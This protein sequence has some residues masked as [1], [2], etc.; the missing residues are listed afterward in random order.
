M[1]AVPDPPVAS[2]Q[3]VA[4]VATDLDGTVVR[5]DGTISARTVAA[6][7]A[8]EDAGLTLVLVTGRPPRWMAPVV[9]ATGHRGLA[10]CAN[11][12]LVYDL[13]AERVVE[14]RALAPALGADLVRDLRAALPGVAFA[15]EGVDGEETTFAREPS[16]QSIF[17]NPQATVCDATELVRRPVAKLLVRHRDAG[18]AR[19]SEVA[20]RVAGDRAVVTYSGSDGQALVEVSA[21][22]VTKASTLERLAAERGVAREQVLAFGDAPN[23]VPMLAWAGRGVAVANAHPAILAVAD[24][25]TADHD[26]DGVAQVLERLLAEGPPPSA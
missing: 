10:I 17:P 1:P 21:A 13:A 24:E 23:D 16:Y 14:V 7:R 9:E 25:V 18:L 2:R 3:G 5:S 4:L 8:V 20:T 6:L 12:A 11:G 26:D 22:G 19:L 15:A